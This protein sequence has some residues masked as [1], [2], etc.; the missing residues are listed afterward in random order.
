[1]NKST[2]KKEFITGNID[3]STI[4]PMALFSEISRIV[5]ESNSRGV[6]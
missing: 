4:R 5:S 2:I 6:D 1:M 3:H